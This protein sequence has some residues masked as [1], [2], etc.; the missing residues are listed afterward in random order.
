[1][2]KM[3][4][5]PII[6]LRYTK[7]NRKDLKLNKHSA[8]I[9]ELLFTHITS[10]VASFVFIFVDFIKFSDKIVVLVR[11]FIFNFVS[12][13]LRF[14]FACRICLYENNI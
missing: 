8:Y 10:A 3:R 1:M 14:V 7:T 2:M 4:H 5:L 12:L 9:I 13:Y 11:N 6:I